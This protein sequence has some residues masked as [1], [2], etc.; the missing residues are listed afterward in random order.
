[1]LGTSIQVPAGIKTSA[2]YTDYA[3][4][5]N[6]SCWASATQ[7]QPAAVN[8]MVQSAIAVHTEDGARQ[9]PFLIGVIGVIGG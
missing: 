5:S 8:D 7:Q 4:F 9:D 1:M 6:E 3:D 2:D